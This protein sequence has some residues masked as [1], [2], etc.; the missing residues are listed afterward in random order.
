MVILL[1]HRLLLNTRM[2]ANSEICGFD[3]GLLC[4]MNLVGQVEQALLDDETE[5]EMTLHIGCEIRSRFGYCCLIY[6]VVGC[7]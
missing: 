5:L 6:L 4:N 2:Q 1:L 7:L 3:L